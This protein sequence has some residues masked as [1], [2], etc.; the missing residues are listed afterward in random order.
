MF[1]LHQ[2][3]NLLTPCELISSAG[4]IS[5]IARKEFSYYVCCTVGKSTEILFSEWMHKFN[6]KA[7]LNS[8]VPLWPLYLNSMFSWK[9]YSICR[10]PYFEGLIFLSQDLISCVTFSESLET[11]TLSFPICKM[12]III[13]LTYFAS[14]VKRSNKNIQEGTLPLNP[15]NYYKNL[16][17]RGVCLFFPHNC[18]NMLWLSVF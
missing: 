18:F 16:A 9:V 5:Y 7:I 11:S 14:A 13:Y 15:N 8:A 1:Y 4:F 6:T 17:E 3:V 12:V 2:I 10:K